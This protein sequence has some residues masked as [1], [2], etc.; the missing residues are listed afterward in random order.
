M[1]FLVNR[2][3]K[4]NV[5]THQ[6]ICPN[7]GTPFEIDERGYADILKQVRNQEYDRDLKLQREAM[8][9]EKASE[10][11]LVKTRSEMIRMELEKTKDEQIQK[12]KNSLETTKAEA[13]SAAKLA[14]SETEQKYSS[15]VHEKE[16]EITRLNGMLNAAKTAQDLAVA[17]AN[18]AAQEQLSKQQE[19]ITA[20]KAK[21]EMAETQ[22]KLHEQEIIARYESQLKDKEELVE[23]YRDLKARQSTKMI[24]ETLEQHCEAAF[25]QVR[26]IGFQNAYFEKDNEISASGSKGDFIFRD[27]DENGMEYVSIMME[28]KNEN[29]TTATKHKNTDFLKELDKDRREKGCEYAV[30]VTMLEADNDF[31]NNGIVD[32]SHIYP[33]MYVIRPQFLI[34]FIT[35]IRNAARNSISYKRE[36]EIQKAQNIDVT[37]FEAKLLDFKD[38]FGR[39]YNLA[40]DRFSKA[41][42]EID[43]TID[44][45]QKVKDNLLSSENNFRLANNKL[46][47]LTIKKLT[48]GNKTMQALFADADDYQS[49]TSK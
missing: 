33:K 3:E 47:D 34:P 39:N 1:S 45:L 12:L 5:G 15:L 44:H 14:A 36:L 7:C 17:N 38:K 9:A 4:K 49:D 8:E 40:S 48:R 13:E 35:I 21:A 29:E 37:N 32:M 46:E 20:L 6:L 2:M 43:K 11:N 26:A 16:S 42:E 24:G 18:G 25:N 19:I 41:I 28:M 31:Y 27:Y 22:S 23:Y 10:I 30:L